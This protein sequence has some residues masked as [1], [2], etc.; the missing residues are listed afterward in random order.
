MLG[1]SQD[2]GSTGAITEGETMLGY[3]ETIGR[4]TDVRDG[5]RQGLDSEAADRQILAETAESALTRILGEL[6]TPNETP[7]TVTIDIALVLDTRGYVSDLPACTT[8]GGCADPKCSCPVKCVCTKLD[9]NSAY[10]KRT[11]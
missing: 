9:H 4:L 2:A 6:V 1:S 5:L 10:G 7:E 11:N 3:L 8:C